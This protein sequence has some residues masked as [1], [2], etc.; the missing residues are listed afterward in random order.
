M[1]QAALTAVVEVDVS[2]LAPGQ[3]RSVDCGDRRVLL[4]NVDGVF[5]AVADRCSH[6]A[7]PLDAGRLTG[8][9]LECPFH[10]A[11]FDVRD[12]SAVAL[13]ARRPIASYPVVE[14]DGTVR[15]SFEPAL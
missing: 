10:G 15:I 4:C 3:T 12:G 1:S 8:C 11:Q 9:I 13:P 6:A 5:Y 7:V 14:T 2:D